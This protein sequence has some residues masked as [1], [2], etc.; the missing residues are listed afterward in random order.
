MADVVVIGAGPTG[1]ATALA[2]AARGA[3]VILAE[4][5]PKAATRFAGEWMHPPGVRQLARLGVDVARLSRASGCGFVLL[6]PGEEPIQLPY[7]RGY[8][9]ARV[10][11]DLVFDLRE[12]AAQNPRISYLPGWGFKE[13]QG[14]DVVL[15]DGSATQVLRPQRVIGADGRNSK[16]RAALNAPST[17]FP[18]S[19]M[20]GVELKGARLPFEGLGHVIAGGP[21]P[22]LFYRVDENT[23]RGCLDVPVELGGGARKKEA[24][25]QG[26]SKVLPHQLRP[27]FMQALSG[28]SPW[29]ATRFAPRTFFGQRNV[30]LAGDAVGHLHPITGMGMTLG[31]LDAT[32]A[33]DCSSLSE[34]EARRGN[35]VVELL[36]NVLYQVLNRDDESALR[37]RRGLF[38]LLRS[39]P[40]ER[41]RTMR[42]LTGEDESP[43]SFVQ[44]FV[45]AAAH[46]LGDSLP[47]HP[48]HIGSDLRWLKWPLSAALSP[49]FGAKQ[50]RLQSSFTSP[51]DDPKALIQMKWQKGQRPPLPD[52]P[53]PVQL[54]T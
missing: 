32:A 22:A 47:L 24:I 41:L 21:G 6:A 18:I 35:Y 13:F 30:W 29:A 7:S 26:F 15:Q 17:V 51:F 28:A 14:D 31:M 3:E 49:V 1:C 12:I 10:H 46:T 53:S 11:H 45:K 37:V 48:T 27:A 33:A 2:F 19:F 43:A 25:Y 44:S 54:S 4:A 16:V 5:Q 50:L 52:G 9:L 38:A 42:I 36:T 8:S 34:Y 20:M 23:I 40:T 39:S